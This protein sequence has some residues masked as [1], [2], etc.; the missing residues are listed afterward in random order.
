MKKLSI[1]ELNMVVNVDGVSETEKLVGEKWGAAFKLLTPSNCPRGGHIDIA[2]LRIRPGRSIS[3]LHYHQR[4]D[5]QHWFLP[6]SNRC[7][8]WV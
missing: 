7:L 3:P 1:N 5:I 6:R 8:Q 2:W 4:G